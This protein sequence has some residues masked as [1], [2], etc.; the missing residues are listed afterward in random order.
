VTFRAADG[1]DIPI[2]IAVRSWAGTRG[3]QTILLLHGA[4]SSSRTWWHVAPQLQEVGFRVLAVDLPGHGDSPSGQRPLTPSSMAE[5]IVDI[6]GSMSI[7]LLVGHSLGSV[8]AVEM[9]AQSPRI[10]RALVLD[11]PPGLRTVKWEGAAAQLPAEQ[12]QAREDPD[13]HAGVVHDNMPHWHPVDCRIAAE[14]LA[15]C[16][17]DGVLDT[18]GA[19]AIGTSQALIPTLA[20][21]TL[22]MLGPDGN[23]VYEFGGGY[24]SSIQGEE[25]QTFISSIAGCATAQFGVGHVLHRDDPAGWASRVARFVDA[26]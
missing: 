23:G 3:G 17:A 25:R 10:A 26:P 11:E 1:L 2:P 12:R 20:L 5:R 8:V 4:T 19:I 13:R 14:D 22:I 9:L 16:D 24:R 7:D 18:L 6:V 15:A 21:P